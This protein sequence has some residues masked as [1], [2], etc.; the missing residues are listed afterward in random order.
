[1]TGLT[2]TARG[3]DW[4][5]PVA[6][7]LITRLCIDNEAVRLLCRNGIE[8]SIAEPFTLDGPGQERHLLEPGGAAPRLAPALG[9]MR[10][11][12]GEGTAFAD[13]RLELQF[14]DGSR[15]S[16][17]GGTDYEAWDLTGP[18]GLT[19]VSIPGGDLAIWS[20]RRPD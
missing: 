1:V 3:D 18:G 20:D 14:R 11:V 17:P 13:G 7:Q 19:V 2:L 5:L 12:L 8:I 16:V 6:G 10:Q 4:T 15:L 9:I